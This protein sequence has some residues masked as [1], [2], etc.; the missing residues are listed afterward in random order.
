[1]ERTKLATFG[2]MT[3]LKFK[4]LFTASTFERMGDKRSLF[5]L[6]KCLRGESQRWHYTTTAE[7]PAPLKRLRWSQLLHLSFQKQYVYANA[8]WLGL[9]PDASDVFLWFDM[10]S[11]RCGAKSPACCADAHQY[12]NLK[13]FLRWR[14]ERKPQFITMIFT[15]ADFEIDL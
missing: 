5:H 4:Q 13:W 6:T 8:L 10:W 14:V 1:M 9:T 12:G 7:K 15:V 11:C 2:T 3:Y